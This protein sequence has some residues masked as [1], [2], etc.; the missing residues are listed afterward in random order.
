[1]S[2]SAWTVRGNGRLMVSAGGFPIVISAR[3]DGIDA[4]ESSR[5]PAR[6]ST[7][8]EGDSMWQRWGVRRQADAGRPAEKYFNDMDDSGRIF[9]SIGSDATRGTRVRQ[10]TNTRTSNQYRARYD[11]ATKGS[12]TPDVY[13]VAETSF[14]PRREHAQ[15]IA[16]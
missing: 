12:E 4:P 7:S 9:T 11:T 8:L 15:G 10:A 13:I 1:M 6:V 2:R 5:V 14:A 16:F 3:G